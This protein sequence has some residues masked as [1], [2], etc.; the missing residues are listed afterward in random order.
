MY[1]IVCRLSYSRLSQLNSCPC[2]NSTASRGSEVLSIFAPVL[3]L[4][5][6]PPPSF[7]SKVK[8]R[9]SKYSKESSVRAEGSYIYEEFMPTDGTD[10]KVYSV[11]PDYAHAEAR[12]SPVSCFSRNCPRIRFCSPDSFYHVVA[13]VQRSDG[14]KTSFMLCVKSIDVE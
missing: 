2:I 9:S 7:F 6:S 1:F 8:D 13:C 12:K 14:D 5:S 3:I 4:L 11:G 10:V